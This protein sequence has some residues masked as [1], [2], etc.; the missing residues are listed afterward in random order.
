MPS[1]ND[2][3]VKACALALREFPRANG[4]Y[5]DGKV[6]EYSRVNVGVAVAAQDALVVPTVF[7]ADAKGLREIAAESASARRP[8]SR[9][10]DH[11]AGA[12]RRNLHRFKP[13]DVRSDQFLGRD[14]PAAGGDPRRRRDRRGA[15]RPRRG[16]R[17]RAADVGRRS[18]AITGS[19]TG[20]TGRS[21]WPRSATYLR[22]RCSWHCEH[23]GGP[24]RQ[25][26]ST[27]TSSLGRSMSRWRSCR[28][29]TST[30]STST[31]PPRRPGRRCS[32]PS[33]RAFNGRFAKRYANPRRRQRRLCRRRPPSSRRDAAGLL[34][35]P[36]DRPGH[37]GP[38]RRAPVREVRGRLPDRPAAGPA[39]ARASSRPERSSSAAG[40]GC[41]RRG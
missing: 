32:R 38:G 3:V 12:V 8:G 13:G 7:D 26:A 27:A 20:P 23:N 41:T 36:R 16:D 25:P 1:F 2:M 28:R 29:S 21:S 35:H 6:E 14:Q 24:A 39:L 22:N 17:P 37:A 40:A 15:R 9:G 4:S 18:R 19:S 33:S 30:P 10:N 34:R 11:A 5:R 31:L